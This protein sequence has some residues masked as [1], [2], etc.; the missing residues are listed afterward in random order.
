MTPSPRNPCLRHEPEVGSCFFDAVR[1]KPVPTDSDGRGSAKAVAVER[2]IAESSNDAVSGKQPVGGRVVKFLLPLKKRATSDTSSDY[3]SDADGSFVV[4]PKKRR[5]ADTGSDSTSAYGIP[6][7]THEYEY[8]TV[9]VC[10]TAARPKPSNS[11]AI[12]VVTAR[13][14]PRQHKKKLMHDGIRSGGVRPPWHD[15]AACE[16]YMEEAETS[17]ARAARAKK[18]TNRTKSRS[19]GPRLTAWEPVTPVERP[20]RPSEELSRQLEMLGT[21]A[22]PRFVCMKTLSDSDV[23]KN[24]NRLLFSCKRE[25][26]EDH[27]ITAIFADNEKETYLTGLRVRT[28]DGHG[29]AYGIRLKYLGS[30]GGYRLITGWHA[31]VE[32]NGLDVAVVMKRRVDLEL[33]EFRSR[34][35]PGQPQLLK[36]KEKDKLKNKQKIVDGL[37]DHPDA[38]LGLLFIPYIDGVD[39]SNVHGAEGEMAREERAEEEERE[40]RVPPIHETK[41]QA[42]AKAVREEKRAREEKRIA[43]RARARANRGKAVAREMT[44][45]EVIEEAGEELAGP[46]I[47]LLTLSSYYCSSVNVPMPTLDNTHRSS[48]TTM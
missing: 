15:L 41:R 18:N 14:P 10:A 30:N 33:W 24:Q 16:G 46:L 22:P 44:I 48:G 9:T 2:S 43:D 38:A 20:L 28:F 27:P 29:R 7:Q 17:A 1:S 25:F 19:N 36:E 39:I 31:F 45:E 13:P 12:A 47:G 4:P 23:T 21:M 37:E 3:H 11:K 40:E 5:A 34:R 8:D 26:V 6:A 42:S 32:A 35:L